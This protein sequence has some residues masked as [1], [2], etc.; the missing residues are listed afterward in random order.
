MLVTAFGPF[1]KPTTRGINPLVCA[2][3]LARFVLSNQLDGV[4]INY[5][6]DFAIA[7]GT[8]EL[9]LS[10]FSHELRRLLPNSIISHSVKPAFFK[11]VGKGYHKVNQ[12]VGYTID[13]YN[14]LYLQ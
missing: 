6:D 3:K 1:E 13:F 5:E 8:A 4:D 12:Q 2:K 9:W 10:V 14:I 11:N 7:T